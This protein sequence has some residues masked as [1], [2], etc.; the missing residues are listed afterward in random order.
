MSPASFASSGTSSS[1][2]RAMSDRPSV[3]A[4]ATVGGSSDELK[5]LFSKRERIAVIAQQFDLR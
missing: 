2:D 5:H 4:A 1:A 3:N